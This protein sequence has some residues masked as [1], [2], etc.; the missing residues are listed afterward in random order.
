MKDVMARNAAILG[1][2]ELPLPAPSCSRASETGTSD[3]VRAVVTSREMC[4][5]M[6]NFRP[7]DVECRWMRM[8]HRY[9]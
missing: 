7:R 1:W 3:K 9:I 5:Y 8:C 4:N 2:V 6:G